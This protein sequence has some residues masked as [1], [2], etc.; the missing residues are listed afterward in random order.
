[1]VAD[2]FRQRT[3]TSKNDCKALWKFN[4]LQ[5]LSPLRTMTSQEQCEGTLML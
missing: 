3:K 1:M 4:M 2:T 5:I